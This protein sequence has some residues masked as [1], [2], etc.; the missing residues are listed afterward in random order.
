MNIP[1]RQSALE[2]AA[3]QPL[4]G[5]DELAGRFPAAP[6]PAPANPAPA[7]PETVQQVL[8]N[9]GFGNYFS[10]HMARAV[11]RKADAAKGGNETAGWSDRALV[12]YGKLDLDPAAAVLHYGQSIFEGLK[13]YRREDDTIWAFRPA[14]NAHRLNASARRLALPQLPV[15]DFLASVIDLVRADARWVPDTPGASLYL[16]PFM[17]ASEAFLG[18]HAAEEITYLCIGSPSGPYFGNGLKA[19][20]IW[21]DQEYHRAGPGGTGAAKTGGNYAAALLPQLQAAEKGYSQVCFLDA[22]TNT[23]LD[24]LGGMNV[25]VVYKDGS[26][27][28]PTLT[29]TILEGGTRGAILQV[30][31]EAG[32]DVSEKRLSL[33]DLLTGLRS[34]QV[35][36]VFACGTAAVVTP[37]GKLGGQDFEIDVPEQKVTQYVHDTIT[38]IQWGRVADTHGWCYRLA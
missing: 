35:T 16:R 9:P 31:A 32:H 19:V 12:P 18:V 8:A 33:T 17:F 22:A 29:G 37:I 10:D 23:Y 28:T 4:P 24:E 5:A 38:G 20:N 30:L 36:E 1:S 27:A 13:A 6:H 25:F 34:G 7:R 11:W 26:V 15:A 3:A 14:F 21:V 2:T